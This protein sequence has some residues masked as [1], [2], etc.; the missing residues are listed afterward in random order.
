LPKGE[1]SDGFKSEITSMEPTD[2]W[3]RKLA[4]FFT[5]ILADAKLHSHFNYFF[6]KRAK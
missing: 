2:E 1:N 3:A 6:I 5:R 4:D